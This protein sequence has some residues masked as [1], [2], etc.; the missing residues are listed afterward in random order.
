MILIDKLWISKDKTNVKILGKVF[1]YILY[2]LN[3][4]STKCGKDKIK[5]FTNKLI[6]IW[7]K[8]IKVKLLK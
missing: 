8:K 6:L 5:V 2:N 7:E 4:T 1:D 3:N